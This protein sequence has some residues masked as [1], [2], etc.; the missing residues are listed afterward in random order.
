[1]NSMAN[2]TT[3]GFLLGGLCVF[4]L[5]YEFLPY[6]TFYSPHGTQKAAERGYAPYTSDSKDIQTQLHAINEVGL[7]LHRVKNDENHQNQIKE[8]S[9][10]AEQ[11]I[12]TVTGITKQALTEKNHNGLSAMDIIATGPIGVASGFSDILSGVPVGESPNKE[13]KQIYQNHNIQKIDLEPQMVD[14]IGN[15]STKAMSDFER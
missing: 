7:V 2:K 11:F 8:D 12:N 15:D 6:D 3:T 14:N 1:M 10:R 4:A 9:N 5:L 13:A